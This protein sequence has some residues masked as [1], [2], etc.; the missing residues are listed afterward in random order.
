MI[1]VLLVLPAYNEAERL[2][3]YLE[4]LLPLLA[5]HP[6]KIELLVVDDGSLPAESASVETAI[7]SLRL[8]FP[9]LR[10]L[11]KLPL[12]QGKGGAIR[13]GW[14]EA[15]TANW[16]GFI[17][18]DGAIPPQEVARLLSMLQENSPSIFASRIKM[19]GRKI[20]RHWQRHA[21]GRI[22]ATL[23][24]RLLNLPVYDS[25]CGFKLI[26]RDSYEKITSSLQETGFC[27]DIELLLAL[28]HIGNEV[29]E[30]PI[31]WHDQPGSK[32]SL[33]RDSF[34]MFQ[35]LLK[36]RKR[37]KGWQSNAR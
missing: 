16:L 32:V 6:I 5:A 10:P 2:P 18:A 31:D 20:T 29:I 26:R 19:L 8:S 23:T 3:R 25:Q 9:Q 24:S 7:E 21:S 11:L 17:D 36:I 30:V 34:R 27:L 33:F 35:G 15:G 28:R 37:S 22:F 12:N 4:Q 14:K 13:T 1:H